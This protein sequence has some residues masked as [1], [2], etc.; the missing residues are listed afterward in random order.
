ML[1]ARVTMVQGMKTTA[2]AGQDMQKHEATG[3]DTRAAILTRAI[4]ANVPL[5]KTFV[6]ANK[7][8]DSR[9]GPLKDFVTGRDLRGLRAYLM[10]VAACSNGEKGWTTE[11]DSA[12]WARLMDVDKTATPQSARTGAWRALCRLADRKLIECS[13]SGTMIKVT[14]LREDGTGKAYDRP[15]GDTEE[16]RFLQIPTTFWTQGR[17]EKLSLPGLA[18]FLVVA[19]EKHWATFP[20]EWAPQWYG[21]SPD[22]HERGLKQL[23]EL[24]YVQARAFKKKAP[25]APLGFTIAQQY[26]RALITRPRKPP[27]KT[28]G[29]TPE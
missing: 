21:W 9:P 17:D 7:G 24:E 5:R 27:K 15:K 12:V 22:T 28:T 6:Q 25:L 23:V 16:N 14:L 4:R 10:I 1:N 3:R 20:A 8:A 29:S 19:R 26:Q 18:L 11:H 13:R 2:N